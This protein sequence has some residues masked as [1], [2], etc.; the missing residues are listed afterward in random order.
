MLNQKAIVNQPTEWSFRSSRNS[1]ACELDIVLDSAELKDFRLPAFY[2]G[3]GEWRFRFSPLQP[4]AYTFRTECSD[5]SNSDLHHVTGSIHAEPYAGEIP[6]FK[7]GAPNV[8]LANGR[9]EYSNGD[10]FFWLADTW[11][12]CLTDRVGWPAEFQALAADR[13]KKGLT[14]IQLVAG[15]IPDA[16]P[17]DPRAANEGGLPWLQ[18]PPALNP[19]FYNA[20]DQKIKHLASIGLSPCIVGAWGYHLPALGMENMRRHWRNLVA[21]YAAL[22]V[23]WCIAGET[24]MPYYLSAKRDEDTQLQREGW[25][26]LAR[27]VRAIDPYRRPITTHPCASQDSHHEVNDAAV[28][29]FNFIQ[30]GHGDIRCASNSLKRARELANKSKLRPVVHSEVCYEGIFGTA[31]DEVQRLLFWASFLSGHSFSY[32]A[33][34]LWQFNTESRQFGASPHGAVWGNVPWKDAAAFPGSS[35]LGLARQIL[36]RYD[37]PAIVPHREWI[38]P[39]ASDENSIGPY[40][41]GIPEK[42]RLFY[43]PEPVVPWGAAVTV[44]KL[45]PGLRYTAKYLC[46]LS[47]AESHLGEVKSDNNGDWRVPLCPVMHDYLLVL[48]RVAE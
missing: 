29:D 2:A 48:E 44:K 40:A 21:R 27:Y 37:W 9:F 13:L 38:A 3:D 30:T 16:P 22:P 7:N 31:K 19:N 28:L 25:T 14:V 33:N 42:L 32:G 4:G 23:F 17:F 18:S 43:F 45:E 12:M 5:R 36:Q 15:L 26:Q 8:N 34:G 46:P 20:A 6:I 11:W 10:P 24:T 47:G 39:A 41:A 1:A 35:H